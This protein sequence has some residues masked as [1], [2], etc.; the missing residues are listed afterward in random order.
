MAVMIC[1]SNPGVDFFNATVKA[2][3]D[4]YIFQESVDGKDASFT[5][6][7]KKNAD[8]TYT[9]SYYYMTALNFRLQR[10]LRMTRDYLHARQKQIR[11]IM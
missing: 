6:E 11:M 5:S 1:M 7:A 3:G 8:G 10:K 4:N 2:T 9:G